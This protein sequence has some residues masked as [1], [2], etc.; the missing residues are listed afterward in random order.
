MKYENY[1]TRKRQ[2]CK[3]LEGDHGGHF[4]VI[5]SQSMGEKEKS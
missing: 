4:K 5:S 2:I 1:Y 3:D